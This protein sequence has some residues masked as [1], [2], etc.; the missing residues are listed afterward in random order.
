MIYGALTHLDENLEPKPD[1]ASKWWLSKSGKQWHFKIKKNIKDHSGSPITPALLA[2]CLEQYRAGEPASNIRASFPLWL[3]T[4]NSFEEVVLELSAP[5]PYLPRNVS[6]LRYFRV[7]GASIPCSEPS[8]KSKV[9]TSGAY[10]PTPWE[11]TPQEDLLLTPFNNPPAP[12]LR[13]L[14]ITDDN[15]KLLK[16]LRGD[17]D[18]TLNTLQPAKVRWLQKNKAKSFK[19]VEREGVQIAYLAFNLRDPLLSNPKIRKAIALSLDRNEIIRTKLSGFTSP[20]FSFLSPLLPESAPLLQSIL[21]YN[22]AQAEKILDQEGFPRDANQKRFLLHYKT[23][24]IREGME[25]ALIFQAMLKKVG[26]ELQIDVVEPAVFFASIRK[27][28]FQ[29]YSSRWLG[30]ADGSILFRTLR[31]GQPNNRAGYEN[32][33]VDRLLDR[34]IQEN[35]LSKRL[36][37]LHKVQLQMLEDLPYFPLWHW[38]NTLILRNTPDRM[39]E[40]I[41]AKNLSLSGAFDPLSRLRTQP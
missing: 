35:N 38:K 25:T 9:I 36:P 12:S 31:S 6:L 15:T 27:G 26:I 11:L 33:E 23:T 34:A 18:V 5:D 29:L 4:R 39:F 30:V 37:L 7:E 24:P 8:S 21:T 1:L 28:A 40:G 19:I 2:S 3:G 13:F 14:F 17:I 32:P 22:T 20:A 41:E 16:L 10:Q